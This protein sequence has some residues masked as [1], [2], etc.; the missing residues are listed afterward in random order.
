MLRTL[1]A[2]CFANISLFTPV[3]AAELSIAVAAN[4]AGPLQA[5]TE[6]FEADSGHQ[7][8]VSP[9]SS[10]RLYAQIINGAPY[11]IFFSADQ[12]K[13]QLLIEAGLADPESR[14]TY[15][16]GSLVLWSYSEDI[17]PLDALRNIAIENLA[18]ANPRLA[19]YGQAA[20][21]VLL[22]FEISDEYESRLVLGENINQ[23]FQFVTT[24]NADAGFIALSQLSSSEE[25]PKGRGWIVPPNLHEPIR[26]D[27][28]IIR[29]SKN[30]G[31]AEDFMSFM[32]SNAGK[33]MISRFGYK[34]D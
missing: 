15:A 26:Q 17:E 25:L 16:E 32:Q 12:E 7:I 31:V 9:G 30:S 20:M 10:G 4:F 3:L 18:I 6:A 34:A 8:T 5:I 22:K 14:V 23:V 28:V 21:E 11:D 24:G 1:F 13:P 33:E 19:P 2:V 29:S 27:A